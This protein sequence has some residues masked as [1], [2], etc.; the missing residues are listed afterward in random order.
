MVSRFSTSVKVLHTNSSSVNLFCRHKIRSHWAWAGHRHVFSPPFLL[1]FRF[2]LDL[3]SVL[4]LKARRWLEACEKI[5]LSK[6]WESCDDLRF[7]LRLSKPKQ[8]LRSFYI[9]IVCAAGWRTTVMGQIYDETSH[10]VSGSGRE[11]PQLGQITLNFDYEM[12]SE[13][14]R[15]VAWSVFQRRVKDIFC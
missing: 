11:I 9:P 2:N 8:S 1:H 5:S 14:T 10:E 3:M 6:L 7:K 15:S 13:Q 12:I 4:V